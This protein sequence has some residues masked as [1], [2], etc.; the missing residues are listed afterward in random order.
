MGRRGLERCYC[1]LHFCLLPTS[2]I[3]G[4]GIAPAHGHPVDQMLGLPISDGSL[5]FALA[6]LVYT[7]EF[8]SERT[9]FFAL[10]GTAAIAV[11][12]GTASS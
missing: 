7:R 10:Q 6:A 9:V 2:P 4:A 5:E 11:S 12:A 1:V 8:K 3:D